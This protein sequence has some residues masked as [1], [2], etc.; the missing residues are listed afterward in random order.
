MKSISN[1]KHPLHTT[2]NFIDGLINDII[3]TTDYDIYYAP[4]KPKNGV[5]NRRTSWLF[6]PQRPPLCHQEK[7]DLFIYN[8]V[9]SPGEQQNSSIKNVNQFIHQ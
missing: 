9:D 8:A 7:Q 1:A 3:L 5:T 4:I 2:V 6:R